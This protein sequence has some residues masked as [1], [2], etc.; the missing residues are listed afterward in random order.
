MSE[1]NAKKPE[2]FGKELKKLLEINK[3][4]IDIYTGNL[5]NRIVRHLKEF[6]ENKFQDTL[7]LKWA[8]DNLKTLLQI[9][10][11]IELN[12][13]KVEETIKSKFEY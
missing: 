6:R 5:Y 3:W 11:L 8:L 4:N 13:K 10:N 7:S 2:E 12:E 1:K 9:A